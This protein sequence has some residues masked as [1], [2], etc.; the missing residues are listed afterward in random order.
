MHDIRKLCLW[1]TLTAGGGG[2]EYYFGYRLPE[3]DLVCQDFRSRDRSWDY[4]RIAIEFFQS[5][6]LPFAEMRNADALVGNKKHDNSRFCLAKTGEAYLVFLPNGGTSEL[7]LSEAAG[8]FSVSWFNPR[9]GGDLAIG[10]VQSVKGGSK[11]QIG[12]PP[13]DAGDDW[14]VIVRR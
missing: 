5:S 3:N 14:A 7:D 10:S 11:V 8:P 9:T 1:G 13:S 12:L 6:G 4:C 2:V